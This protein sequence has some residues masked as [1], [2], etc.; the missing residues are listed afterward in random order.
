M[1][2]LDDV[3]GEDGILAGD[4]TQAAYYGAVHFL[5]MGARRRFLYPTGLRDARATRCRPR[6]ARSSRRR[7][8]P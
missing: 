2:V 6:S 4:S 3:L 7:T 1:E 8:A 5:P